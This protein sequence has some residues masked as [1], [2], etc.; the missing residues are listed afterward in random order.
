MALK[1]ITCEILWFKQKLRFDI[2]YFDLLQPRREV[3]Y[4]RRFRSGL[5]HSEKCGRDIQYESALEDQPVRIPYWRGR[6]KVTY[7]PDYGIYLDSGHVVLVEV[8]ELSEMLDY[9]VQ[10]KTEALM[11][12]CSDRGFGLLLTD[13][14][15]TP[16]D[17]LKG[18]V[19]RRLER[20]LLA[21]LDEHPLRQAECREIMDRCH[22]TSAEL[23]Q[24]HHPSATQ[25][26]SISDET[27]KR[28]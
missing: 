22:A 11:A 14:R 13:G 6:R 7:T 1:D 16:R 9:R 8:K 27:A 25:I 21:A 17:L 20:A 15:H 19:N 10:Q 5:F 28:K 24:N 3:S 26:P 23:P 12:F 18:K 4:D 2:D